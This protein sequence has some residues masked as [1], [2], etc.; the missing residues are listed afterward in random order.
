[1]VE[2][3]SESLRGLLGVVLT[4][5]LV[6]L[7]G[8]LLVVGKSVLLPIFVA[9]ISVYVLVAASD[10]VARVPGARHLPEWVRRGVV[11][12]LFLLV[13]NMLAGIMIST[14]DEIGARLPEYRQNAAAL[15]S[16]LLSLFGVDNPDWRSMWQ[17][18]VDDIPVESVARTALASISAAAG[19]VFMVV[20]YAVFLMGERGGF[21]R[22]IA[23]ALPGRRGERAAR[24]VDRVNTSIS[25][26]LTVKTLV[27]VIL[28]VVSYAVMWAFGVDFA[29]FWAVLIAL[30][31]YIPYI[32][33]LL[34]VAFPVVLSMAQFGSLSTTLAVAALLT[35]AQTI[36][37]S[38]LEPRM[39]GRKVNMS[40]FVVLVALAIWSSIWGVAGAILAIPLTSIIAIVM[41]SFSATRP[42]AVLLAEDV[43][44]YE[45]RDP[46]ESGR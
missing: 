33:S 17:E 35:A 4:L 11:L 29:L 28:G 8:F 41:G 16:R 39:V 46:S 40:P 23:V 42:F 9:V 22:K 32:G 45:D 20:I 44:V 12:G 15:L 7:V 1:M 3:G 13:V 27:N 24:I 6:V 31:N 21:A 19:L 34:G 2:P 18:A 30:M 10:A 37:G 38:V 14:A 43:G 26:Y 25:D 5:S 36:V